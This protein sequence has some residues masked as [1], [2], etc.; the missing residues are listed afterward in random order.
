MA[1]LMLATV[2]DLDDDLIYGVLGLLDW[3][4]EIIII[5]T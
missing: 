2:E 4:L 5:S 3:S 1:F